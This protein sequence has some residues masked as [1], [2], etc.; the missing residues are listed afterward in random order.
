MLALYAN[1]ATSLYKLEEKINI[2]ENNE[3]MEVDNLGQAIMKILGSEQKKIKKLRI[4]ALSTTIIQ[5]VVRNALDSSNSFVENCVLL[6]CKPYTDEYEVEAK[7]I[8]KRWEENQHIA[9]IEAVEYPTKLSDYCIIVDRE[10]IIWGYY[11]FTSK[12]SSGL[13]VSSVAV[14]ANS[15][16]VGQRFIDDCI[17]RFD[18]SYDYF[19]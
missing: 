19:K 14:V 7:T 5:P 18:I 15:R 17:K 13:S 9:C 1:M 6:T 4:F 2:F 16:K 12:D 10:T 3:I 8:L 11:T